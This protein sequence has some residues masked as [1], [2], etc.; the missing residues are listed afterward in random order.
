MVN[1]EAIIYYIILTDS[2]IANIVSWCCAGWYKKNAKKFYRQFPI[3]KGWCIWYFILVL[4]IGYGLLR[5]G[6]LPG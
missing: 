5:L 3:T 6:V 1:I 2:I 4:W